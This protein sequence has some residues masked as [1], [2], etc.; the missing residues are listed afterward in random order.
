MKDESRSDVQ[1]KASKGTVV[2]GHWGT[3]ELCG[4]GRCPA[5][6]SVEELRW[7]PVA[8]RMQDSV[9]EGKTETTWRV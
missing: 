8:R 7:R 5:E 6:A 1:I 2:E 4:K 3:R 9:G